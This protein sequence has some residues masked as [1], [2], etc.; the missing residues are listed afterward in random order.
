MKNNRTML[1]KLNKI[2]NTR[3]KLPPGQYRFH[4]TVEKQLIK[5]N[6]RDMLSF[7]QPQSRFPFH[8]CYVRSTVGY[9]LTD[10]VETKW[11]RV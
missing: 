8:G 6:Y 4:E 5:I 11:N 9:P 3:V 1:K 10:A 2:D 7:M